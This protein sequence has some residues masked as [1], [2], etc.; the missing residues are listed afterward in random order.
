M[1]IQDAQANEASD[2][3]TVWL[4]RWIAES[5]SI[6]VEEIEE[7]K[8]LLDYSLS[9]VTATIMVGDL[10]EW[11]GLTLPPT[12]VWDYPSIADLVNYLAEQVGGPAA[13][14]A[15]SAETSEPMRTTTAHS[16]LDTDPNKL[17]SNMDQFSDAEVSAMLDQLMAD[18]RVEACCRVPEQRGETISI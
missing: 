8:S 5:L 1:T 14:S 7:S 15:I 16:V 18:E 4:K 11:L 9:S 10:E 6:P 13:E 17:L 3:I 12:L 2:P